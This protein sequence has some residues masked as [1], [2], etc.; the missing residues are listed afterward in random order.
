MSKE[1]RDAVKEFMDENG[2]AKFTNKELIIYFNKR[3]DKRM[4]GLETKIDRLPCLKHGDDILKIK[5]TNKVIIKVIGISI[6]I[7]GLTMAY[8]KFG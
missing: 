4:D 6:S 3:H 8:M 1:I 5:T 2:N 7:I